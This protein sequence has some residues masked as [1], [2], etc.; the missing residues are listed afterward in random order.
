MVTLYGSGFQP[1]KP[2]DTGPIGWVRI[3][4]PG[5][6]YTTAPAVTIQAPRSGTTATATATID[7]AG[8][9]TAITIVDGGSGY[10]TG[11]LYSVT[12][13]PSPTSPV[14]DATAVAVP[15]ARTAVKFAEGGEAVPTSV[16]DTQITVVV[17]DGAVTGKISVVTWRGEGTSLERFE[18]PGTTPALQTHL[19]NHSGGSGQDNQLNGLAVVDWL[20]AW[21]VGDHGTILSFDRM[22][23]ETAVAPSSGWVRTPQVSL[24]A[25]DS[26]SGV[27]WV[28]WI[29]RPTGHQRR[30]QSA[31]RRLGQLGVAIRNDGHVG[32][33]RGQRRAGHPARDLLPGARQYG[34][35]G[36]R[37]VLAEEGGP[38][39]TPLR[40]CRSPST[41]G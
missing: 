3:S 9:V 37:P 25:G 15:A 14:G 13:A 4:D 38:E 7:A 27:A 34:Q 6:G 39:A 2:G 18:V 24:S 17:P 16:S 33:Y 12:I 22:P 41:C 8:T 30:H 31:H 5:S 28:R 40:T 1:W 23:P 21:T 19:L 20:N 35:H 11:S 29:D 10:S 26:K 32:R 36:A